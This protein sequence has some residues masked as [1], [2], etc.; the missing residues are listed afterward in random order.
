MAIGHAHEH[1]RLAE[2]HRRHARPPADHARQRADAIE[3]LLKKTTRFGRRVEAARREH[4]HHR[5]VVAAEPGIDA[6]ESAR[7]CGR[8]ARRRPRAPAPRR[9]STT[10]SAPRMPRREPLRPSRS[11]V[12]GRRPRQLQRRRQARDS[13]AAIVTPQAIAA[14]RPSIGMRSTSAMSAGRSRAIAS[15][16]QRASSEP[17]A[18]PRPRAAGSRPASAAPAGGGWRRA[19]GAPR[20]RARA[21]RRAPAA[22]SRRWRRRRQQEHGGAEQ[23]RQHVAQAADEMR[24]QRHDLRADRRVRSRILA[25]ELRRDAR[26]ARPAPRPTDTPGR[27]RPSTFQNACA[28]QVRLEVVE[29]LLRQPHQRLRPPRAIVEQPQ[30]EA[31]RQHAD[32]GVGVAVVEPHARADDRGIA[33]EPA[34]HSAWLS[35]TTRGPPRR[36]SCGR[37]V[38]PCST[39]RAQHGEEPLAD[40]RRRQILGLAAGEVQIEA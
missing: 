4:L 15:S 10:T 18:P 14:A 31:R 11:A 7:S 35:T 40:A 5:H 2:R 13:A 29:A 28:A 25:R 17:D 16:V 30:L 32:D 26:R 19:P 22:D 3:R 37:N 27:S 36:Y 34:V 12:H 8:A 21:R 39:R 24:A 38:R 33:A 6:A 1:P 20:T 23:Q 9:S